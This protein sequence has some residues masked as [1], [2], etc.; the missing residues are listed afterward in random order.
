V[1]VNASVATSVPL[2]S[3]LNL[4]LRLQSDTMGRIQQAL[5]V[6]T[7]AIV[8]HW[9]ADRNTQ[10][11][12]SLLVGSSNSV[13]LF[14][15]RVVT[16]D[17]TLS[18]V[19]HVVDGRIDAV[20]HSDSAPEGALDYSDAVIS[21]VRSCEGPRPHDSAQLT[22]AIATIATQGLVDVHVH[23]NEPGRCAERSCGRLFFLADPFTVPTGK[24]SSR[25]RVGLQLAA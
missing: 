6:V 12:C 8:L 1:P 3:D 15:R 4:W 19:V 5:A 2:A 10:S 13:Q 11:A 24:A 22:Q 18:A 23:L 25:V 7:L 21:P 14:S 17:G 16:P 9:A 20:V